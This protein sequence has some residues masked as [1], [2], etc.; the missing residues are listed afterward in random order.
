[1][2]DRQ[3][4]SF[5]KI[6]ET[7]SFSKAAKDSFISVPAMVQQIDRLEEDLG[8]RLLLRSNQGVRL[9][10]QGKIFYDAVLEMQKIYKEAVAQIK[11]GET[12]EINIGVAL[13]QCPGFL[14][15]GCSSFQKKYPQT[16]LHFKELPYE[17]HLDMIRQGK[18]DLT[19][20]AKPKNS[21]LNELVYQ[22]LCIDT[23]AFGVN[24]ESALARKK[25]IRPQDLKDVRVLCGTYEY[26]EASFEEMLKDTGA[27]M[28]D[29]HTEYN[30]ESM[31]Q[32]KFQE[33]LLVFH[34]HWEN[35]YSHI[36]KVLP[37]HIIAGSVGAVMRKGEEKRL[38]DLVNE[39]QKAV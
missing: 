16:V 36:L 24:G 10:D 11:S 14:M 32:A 9:T 22:E 6:V 3:F 25:K 17:Q 13:N 7:G 34:S 28:Q 19:V 31:V 20:I 35:C 1:M 30:L 23:C 8:F 2:N 21:R 39:I 4:L 27:K 37:S 29:L 12:K 18:I 33:S 5:I 38:E 26:M 15:N